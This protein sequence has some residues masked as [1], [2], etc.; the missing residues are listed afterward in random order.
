[1]LDKTG[2]RRV[3][4]AVAKDRHDVQGGRAKL[5][6]PIHYVLPKREVGPASPAEG[7]QRE[8]RIR[9]K[10]ARRGKEAVAEAKNRPKHAE[11]Q[12]AANHERLQGRTN[13]KRATQDR[14]GHFREEQP[15]DLA[16]RAGGDDPAELHQRALED[17]SQREHRQDELQSE[18]LVTQQLFSV[19]NLS[20]YVQN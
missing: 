11:S 4:A 20:E 7:L 1:M 3:L 9:L 13:R 17:D 10:V 19:Q 8:A 6:E 15:N 18:H 14:R 5:R 2:R 16:E 12:L